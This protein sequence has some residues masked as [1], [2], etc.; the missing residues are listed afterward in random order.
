MRYLY[1]LIVCF[2]FL[3]TRAQNTHDVSIMTYN[4]LNYRNFPSWCSSSVNPPADKE[5]HLDTIVRYAQPDI[6]L[7]TEIGSSANNLTYLLN[8]ALNTSGTTKWTHAPY[9]HNGFSYLVNA[10]YYDSTQYGLLQQFAITED[11]Q[12][13]DL[14][15][16]LD[17]YRMYYK[18]PL[19]TAQSDT[20]TFIIVGLHL[21]AGSGSSDAAK[22]GKAAQALVDYL[23]TN[24]VTDNVLVM[25]D[26]NVYKSSEAA[27]STLTTGATTWFYDPISTPGNWNNNSSFAA[28]HT[29]ST[30]TSSSCFSGGGLD[31]RF[32][33]ILVTQNI[34]GGTNQMTYKTGSYVAI[35]N[36][37]NHFNQDLNSGTNNSVP[38][39]VLYALYNNSDHLPVMATFSLAKILST[40]EEDLVQPQTVYLTGQTVTTAAGSTWTLTEPSGRTVWTGSA[41]GE[42]ITLPQL[43]VGYYVLSVELDNTTSRRMILLQ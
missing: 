2:A 3:G 7:F 20:V 39:N 6:M 32:D 16:Q 19:L 4:L 25:G 42:L 31:D 21:K 1:T 11:A 35:G 27:Y 36:D 9:A 24:N 29:Q 14:T 43:P 41:D 38:S 28:V 33:Q 18:D 22:R 5:A 13:D 15:R 37:G 34:I 12:G 23:N 40:A 10:L 26:F 30:R 17:G 8:N